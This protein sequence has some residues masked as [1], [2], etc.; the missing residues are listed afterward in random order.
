M[1]RTLK[2][3]QQKLEYLDKYTFAIVDTETS[4]TSPNN[5]QIIEIGI[6]RVE[7]GK[8]V[9]TYK[10]L[11]KPA[12]MIPKV[13]TSITGIQPEDLE[14]A[15]AF[16]EVALDIREMLEGAVMVAHNARFDY[17][18]IKNEFKR[19]GI[20]YNA[21]TLCTVKL[22]RE[23]F[24]QYS[25]HNLDAVIEAHGLRCINRHRA[26]DDADALWQF[27]QVVEKKIEKEKMVATIEKLLGNHTLPTGLSREMLRG[28]PNT[29]GVYIFYGADNEVLYVGKSVNIRTRVLSHFSGDHQT[30]K[31]LRMT[32]EVAHVGF[33]E[34]TGELSALFLESKLIKELIPVY[35]RALRKAKQLA[36]MTRTET[37]RGYSSV[38]VSYASY[39]DPTEGEVL[40]IFRTKR[41][42]KDFLDS[43]V[44]DHAL[45]PKLLGVEQGTGAC[46]QQQLGHCQGACVGAERVHDYNARFS[47]VFAA[48]KIKTWPYKGPVV[49][50]EDAEAEEGTAYVI[51][52]WRL[53]AKINYTNESHDEE[54]VGESEFDYDAYKILIK[55]FMKREV[56]RSIVPYKPISY[57]FSL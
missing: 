13:I 57:T 51:D 22:S 11:I 30:A 42:A 25:H 27:L 9:R 17:S 48:R 10:T 37:E 26:Y 28:L 54:A 18:F 40:G 38:S 36:V 5:N 29:P 43:V 52:N 15:P 35:N 12:R 2:K 3:L 49:V 46:F 4:G 31:E 41:Q 16:E 23:L 53:V 39:V 7:Q 47:G 50:K 8:V 14:D 32:G 1:V 44:R 56:Q 6:L 34:T 45:C 24:P 19:L 21:K 33:E 55:H 20:P